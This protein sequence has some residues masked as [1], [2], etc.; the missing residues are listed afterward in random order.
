MN[1]NE[2]DIITLSND[3][4]Y[5]VVKKVYYNNLAYYYIANINDL[6]DVKFL[7]EDNNELVE[8][9]EKNHIRTLIDIMLPEID[10]DEFLEDLR[11]RLDTK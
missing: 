7:Y 9:E 4:D 2:K 6:A 11:S 1:I 10:L 8:I 3:I 5:I